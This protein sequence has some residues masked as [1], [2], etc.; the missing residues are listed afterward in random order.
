MEKQKLT[1]TFVDPNTPQ[2]FERV[3]SRIL[4]E[5]LCASQEERNAV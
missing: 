5:K 1:Y 4:I 3:L 2:D